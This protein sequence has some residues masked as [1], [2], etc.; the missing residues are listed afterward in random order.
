[1]SYLRGRHTLFFRSFILFLLKILLFT[2]YTLQEILVKKLLFKGLCIIVTRKKSA[3]GSLRSFQ[4][5]GRTDGRTDR[6]TDKQT[7]RQTAIQRNKGAN[8]LKDRQT[9][10]LS[11]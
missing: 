8:V 9:N 11:L 4:T 6:H 3:F 5:E 1:M 10:L 2:D 7:N